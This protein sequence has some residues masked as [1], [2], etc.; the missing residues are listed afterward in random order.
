M[1]SMM[2]LRWKLWEGASWLAYWLCPDKKALTL[3][4]KHG[5]IVSRAALQAARDERP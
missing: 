3:I 1:S 2:E 5:T 4:M